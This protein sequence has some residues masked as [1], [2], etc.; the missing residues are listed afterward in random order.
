MS[1]ATKS[2][3]EKYIQKL[4]PWDLHE[5][6]SYEPAFLSGEIDIRHGQTELALID[7]REAVARDPGHALAWSGL[8]RA[9]MHIRDLEVAR[10]AYGKLAPLSAVLS[11]RMADEFPEVLQ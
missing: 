6:K 11:N 1:G 8:L 7:Y 2:L 10:F 4:E 3:P 9:S 5:L